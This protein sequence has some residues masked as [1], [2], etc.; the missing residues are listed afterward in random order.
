MKIAFPVMEDRGLESPVHNHFGSAAYF[1][2]ADTQAG[3]VTSAANPDQDHLH[4]Q[5]QPLRALGGNQVE[6][7][8]VG[9]IGRGA[10]QKLTAAEIKVYRAVEGTVKENLELIQKGHLPEF[11]ANQTCAGH[12]TIGVCIH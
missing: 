5:C 8:V 1:V 7:L 12:A 3:T 2:V 10:L 4:G 9:G 11:G 6:A